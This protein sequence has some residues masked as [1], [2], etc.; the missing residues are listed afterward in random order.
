MDK[1][2]KSTGTGKK[3]GGKKK[4]D[5]RKQIIMR[6]SIT[7]AV[8]LVVIIAIVLFVKKGKKTTDD[9]ATTTEKVTEIKDATTENK[10]ESTTEEIITKD[11]MVMSDL[12]G[13]WIDESLA[14][15]RPVCIMINNIIDAIPQSG[16]GS[17]DVIFE[18]KVEGSL[19]RLLA[20]FKD[21]DDI[22]KLGPVRSA[23]HYYVEMADMLDGIYCHFGWS[24]LAEQRIPELGVNNINGLFYEGL[25]YY[26][27]SSRYAPH[28]VYTNGEMINDGIDAENYSRDY[29][30]NHDKVFAFNQEDKK[31]GSGK[32]ANTIKTAYA[33]NSPW[34]EY[35]AET[36]LYNRFQYS[37]AHIDDQT[38]EQLKFKNV[39]VMLAQYTSLDGVDH[40]DLNWDKG[41][42]AFYATDGEYIEI[43]WKLDNG[44]LK[45][46]T[47][48]GKQLKMNPG[49]TFVA[50]F[51]EK[52]PEG[53]TFE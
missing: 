14:N 15:H 29:I 20:V 5:R 30:K 3:T 23:R 49:K 44:V 17:A 39:I 41:G 26:R 1:N 4:I 38:G 28:D 47:E 24:P 12:T 42:K 7:A 27:D 48:D 19:T 21:Y 33:H 40:Q 31:L 13:E 25:V 45:F 36:G 6:C 2:S 46:F 53:V 50:V 11:G 35:D 10:N 18:F 22:T 43:T 52:N 34:F 32:T 51:D 37:V 8:V 16:I 9:T